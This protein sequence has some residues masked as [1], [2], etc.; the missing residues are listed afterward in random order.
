LNSTDECAVIG[1]FPPPL[2]ASKRRGALEQD[3]DVQSLLTWRLHVRL[4]IMERTLR[5]MLKD[6]AFTNV[7]A[8]RSKT[9]SAIRGRRNRTTELRIQM[10]L[11][12]KCMHGFVMNPS[13][14]LGR[15]DLFFP[16]A[17]V[18]VFVDGCFWHGCPLCG[19]VPKTRS[20]FWSRKIRNNKQRDLQTTRALRQKGI[21]VLRI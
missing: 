4:E 20:E 15:P 18:A 21:Q 17:K 14:M 6:G 3:Y 8:I 11:V 16:E 5:R 2:K 7:S 10:G 13:S 19:H 9:M 12:R 1:L